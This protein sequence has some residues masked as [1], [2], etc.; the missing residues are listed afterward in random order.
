MSYSIVSQHTMCLRWE[1]EFLEC[2]PFLG[3]NC[4]EWWWWSYCE[5]NVSRDSAI[6]TRRRSTFSFLTW[7]LAHI[8]FGWGR[9]LQENIPVFISND[10]DDWNDEFF[11][12]VRL[13]FIYRKITIEIFRPRASFVGRC[14]ATWDCK[15]WYVRWRVNDT[16]CM[17][18][19][20]D[21]QQRWPFCCLLWGL[22]L[23]ET[24]HEQQCYF[25]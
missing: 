8:A 3:V 21:S 11:I 22:L 17:N 15:F 13:L 16:D 4:D 12:I 10:D 5:S 23:R 2:K 25:S 24:Q 14:A 1:R 20:T 7:H 19:A 18:R 9:D 6:R